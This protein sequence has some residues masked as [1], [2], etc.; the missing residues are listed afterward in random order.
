M[1]TTIYRGLAVIASAVEARRPVVYVRGEMRPKDV[2]ERL[3]VLGVN[4][5]TLLDAEVF[6][7]V[8]VTRFEQFLERHGGWASGGVVVFDRPRGGHRHRWTYI[9]QNQDIY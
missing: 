4:P 1:A 5:A 7:S 6:R 8:P 9:R 2:Q 3:H